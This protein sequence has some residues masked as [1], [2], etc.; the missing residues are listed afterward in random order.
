MEPD[1][2]KPAPQVKSLRFQTSAEPTPPRENPVPKFLALFRAKGLTTEEVASVTGVSLPLMNAILADYGEDRFAELC[3]TY[4]T[5]VSKGPEERIKV[6]AELAISRCLAI[7]SNPST[8]SKEVLQIAKDFMDRHFGKALQRTEF[9]GTFQVGEGNKEI[10][11][12]LVAANK[13]LD[14]LM[15]MRNKMLESR[16][17]NAAPVPVEAEILSSSPSR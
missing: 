12:N 16:N 5:K 7:L 9:V 15:L 4:A 10:E 13:R 11:A 1:L 2:S 6:V 17:A 14:E 3:T 8:G